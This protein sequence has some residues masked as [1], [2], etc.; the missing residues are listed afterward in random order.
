[1][2]SDYQLT[3]AVMYDV[4]GYLKFDIHITVFHKSNEVDFK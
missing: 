2:L 1:M 3:I 4:G